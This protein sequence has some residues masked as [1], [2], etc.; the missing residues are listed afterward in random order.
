MVGPK[1]TSELHAHLI[2]P[3]IVI[4]K[5]FPPKIFRDLLSF[6]KKYL[7]FNMVYIWGF[8]IRFLFEKSASTILK[9][10][11]LSKMCHQ[12]LGLARSWL[13]KAAPHADVLGHP[14]S[15]DTKSQ[16][17]PCPITVA[18]FNAPIHLFPCSH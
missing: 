10:G 1:K 12:H 14:W 15:S 2:A 9:C 11:C 3:K 16:W 18:I 6:R 8:Y 13:G 7:F 5:L 4:L 17:H